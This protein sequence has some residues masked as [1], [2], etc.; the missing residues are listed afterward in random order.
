MARREGKPATRRTRPV[1]PGDSTARAAITA[2]PDI[3]DLVDRFRRNRD[4]YRDPAYKEA[5]LRLERETSALHP[6]RL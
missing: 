4:A 1:A 5:P 6:H 3:L 2:P